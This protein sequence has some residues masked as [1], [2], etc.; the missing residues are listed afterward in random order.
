MSA[1]SLISRRLRARRTPAARAD[2]D[3]AAPLR[4]HLGCGPYVVEGWEN[5]D[6]SPSVLLAHMPILRRAMHRAGMI[7]DFQARG[8]PTNIV[9]ADVTRRLPYPSGSAAF[10][11]SSHLI[12]HL[13]RW[14]AL[15]FARECARVLA[16]GGLMRVC[17]PDLREMT[18]SYLQG[19]IRGEAENGWGTAADAFMSEVNAFSE[20]P[21]SFLQ[22]FIRRQ[23]SGAIHQWLYDAK[24]LV[25][26]LEQGGLP[27]AAVRTFRVGELPDL[28]LLET[29]P[30]GLFMEVRRPSGRLLEP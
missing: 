2:G 9:Y 27:G 18:G 29:R 25:L 14:Q 16:P 11:Y 19:E 7:S 20:I 1:V 24:S 5:V 8:F 21:G 23:F 3:G 28:D 12:E 17:T 4:L 6:K 13:S 22:R 15:D 30:V 10:V 26:L